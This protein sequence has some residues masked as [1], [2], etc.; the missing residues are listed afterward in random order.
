MTMSTA[1]L[2]ARAKRYRE[3]VDGMIRESQL[4]RGRK[5]GL[6][7]QEMLEYTLVLVQA[8]EFLGDAGRIMQHTAD[9]I[10]AEAKKGG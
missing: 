9:R 6:T 5:L 1:R 3:L 4:A 7:R 10:D 2:R 8:V